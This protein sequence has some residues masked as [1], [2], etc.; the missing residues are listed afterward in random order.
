MPE[1]EEAVDRASSVH[2]RPSFMEVARVT[3][4]EIPPITPTTLEDAVL[5]RAVSGI[6]RPPAIFGSTRR[7]LLII[8]VCTWAPASQVVFFL[9]SVSNA[10][11]AAIGLV[12]VGLEI[13]ATELGISQGEIS[14][15][16]SALSLSG[17]SFLLLGGRLA[18][19]YG[20]KR[21]LTWSM[22]GFTIWTL[23]ASFATEK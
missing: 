23:I 9:P 17:G 10:K 18:D 1:K 19:I 2:E 13:T 16:P 21:M 7:E 5:T 11:A 22:V 20:R 3:T 14:W 12:L 15:I 8:S 6:D 4:G